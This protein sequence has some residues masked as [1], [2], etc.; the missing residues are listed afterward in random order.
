MRV[1]D[2]GQNY[3]ISDRS[4]TKFSFNSFIKLDYKQSLLSLRASSLETKKASGK[5]WGEVPL[6]PN[7]RAAISASPVSFGL[8][9]KN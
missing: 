6:I 8:K 3:L 2:A 1:E 5:M 9:V 7:F 4:I